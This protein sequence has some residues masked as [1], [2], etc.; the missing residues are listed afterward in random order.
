MYE[1][2][3]KRTVASQMADAAGTTSTVRIGAKSANGHAVEFSASGTII[4]FPGFLAAYEE[5]REKDRYEDDE[6]QGRRREGG[7]PAA[8]R[9]GPGRRGRGSRARHARDHAA[10]A[11]HAGLHD[12][13]ARGPQVR[14]PV[15]VRVDRGP[16]RGPR[17]RARRQPDAHPHV[18]RVLDRRPHGAALRLAH[19]LRLHGRH[20][21]GA[22]PHRDRQG[23]SHR[24]AEHLLLWHGRRDRGPR[25]GPQEARREPGRHRRPCHQHLPGGRG[26]LAA[27]RPLRAV[28]RAR[29]RRRDAARIG[30]RGHG[31][32]RADGCRVR[33]T[34]R[35]TRAAT[36]ASS[37]STPSPGCPWSPRRAASARTSPRC[38]PRARRTSRARRR[39][40]RRCSSRP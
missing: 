33:G 23:R 24:V 20:G 31:A 37:A 29:R 10:A 15:D 28:R 4:T 35:A 12:Q 11:L 18:D 17:L 5:S 25:R 40:S 22:R 14:A 13:G 7:A 8:A 9:R 6:A 27:R 3:W 38:C 36:S 16:D 21:G 32:R 2:I 1:L 26:N 34:V 39:C 30:A 19:R